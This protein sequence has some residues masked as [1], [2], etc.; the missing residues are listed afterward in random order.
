MREIHLICNAH[1]DPIWQWDWQEGVSAVISTFASAANLAEKHDYVFCHNEVTVYKYVEEYAPELFEKIKKLVKKGKWHIMGGWY[2]QPDC[3]MPSGESFV[4]QINVGK[5]YFKDKFGVVPTV[6]I[7]FDPFGHTRGLVQ[8]LNKCGYTGYMF[9][10]PFISE[11]EL[12]SEHFLWKGLDGS[13]IKAVRTGAY[14]S[15]LGKAAEQIEL[16]ANKKEGD[17][18]CVL[19]G[20]GNHGGG[21]SDKDLTDIENLINNSKDK[22]YIHSTPERFFEKIQP[23]KVYDKSLRISMPGC[24]TSMNKIKQKHIALENE[25]SFAEIILSVAYAG[26]FLPHYPTEKISTIEE[27]L[28]NSEFHDVLPGSCVKSGEDNGL[29]LLNHG[30]LEAEKLKTKAYFALLASQKPAS[31]GEYP[32]IVFNPNPYTLKQNVECEFS[33][34]DQNWD[35]ENL[36]EIKI[37]D[38]KGCKLPMQVVKEESTINLDWRKRII[39]EATLKPLGLSRFSVF[40][41]FGKKKKTEN[42]PNYVYSDGKKYV[43]IDGKTG[44]LKKYSLNGKDYVL[45]GFRLMSFNDNADPWGMGDFQQK[46][47]GE[48]GQPFVLS[49]K[50]SGVFEGLK[51]INI[52]EDGEI[53]TGIEAFFEKDNSRARIL[54]KIYKNNEYVDVDVS[55]F[56]GDVN[57][58]IKLEIP[59][60][61]SGKLIGQ[62]AF[63]SEELFTD[64]RENIAHRFL[65]VEQGEECFAIMNDCVYGSH[66]ENGSI[67]LSLVRGVSYCAHPI[68][69]RELMPRDRFVKK[70]DQGESNFSFR[71]GAIKRNELERKTTEFV[72]RPYALNVF[73]AGKYV[74]GSK[75]FGF[76]TDDNVISLI[77]VKKAADSEKLIFRLLN[78][79]ECE[80]KTAA[81]YRGITLPLSFGKNEVKTVVYEDGKLYDNFELII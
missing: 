42:K 21:P 45:N 79:T 16:R 36:S 58:I 30:L 77:T 39:F 41:E 32:I 70:I 14:N 31:A 18:V 73:P 51:S 69:D 78:N 72:R 4:R 43:E 7:N 6:A 60:S 15:P 53:Y 35:T 26:K 80:V 48:N 63:G 65:A 22:K 20:V 11:T 52:I 67:F 49:E 81:H 50:P 13:T 47:L 28:L 54:Y 23:D 75:E 46:R 40:V 76:Y 8:I 57:K 29:K 44:L 1:I 27:D 9:M 12:P 33:L 62:T 66:Y 74:A 17:V 3:N 38:E 37:F 56:F 19:W 68:P 34:A 24:Y 64:A 55:L 2:L 71:I 59:V 25:L 10:R 61:V 5:R